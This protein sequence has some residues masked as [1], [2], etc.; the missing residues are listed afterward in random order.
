MKKGLI[1]IPVIKFA[2]NVI[3]KNCIYY[4]QHNRSITF[5]ECTKFGEKNIISGVIRYV[6]ALNSRNDDD[7]CGKRGLYYVEK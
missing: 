7:L 6:S 5:D 4:K 2:D 1:F 3:C